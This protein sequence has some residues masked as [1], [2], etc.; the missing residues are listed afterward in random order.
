[1]AVYLALAEHASDAQAETFEARRGEIAARAGVNVRTVDAGLAVLVKSRVLHVER[2]RIDATTN[3]PSL[4]TLLSFGGIIKPLGGDINSPPSASIPLVA[5]CTEKVTTAPLLKKLRRTEKNLNLAP[6]EP[7]QVRDELF[8]ALAL[9]EG[10]DPDQLTEGASKRIAVALA[11]IRRATPTVTPQMISD[12]ADVYRSRVM[13]AG[14]RLTAHA[15]AMHW[16]KCGQRPMTAGTSPPLA[17]TTGW[18]ATLEQLFP[19]NAVSA[20]PER[21]WASVDPDTRA[22]VI[23][24]STGRAA[25]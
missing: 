7:A 15:L 3:L 19:G 17:A 13:P 23:G 18:R 24:H 5:K 14:N 16:A 4:Y 25:P 11:Q 2:R 21:T 8:L 9:A 12:R 1:L 10:S 22:K 20:D 6:A